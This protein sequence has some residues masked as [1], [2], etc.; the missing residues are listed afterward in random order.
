MLGLERLRAAFGALLT[1]CGLVA[2]VITFAVMCLVVTNAL[3]R[4]AFNAP[5]TGALELTEAALPLMIFL[6]LALTQAAGGHIK[7]VL[8][9]GRLPQGLARAAT[10]LAMLLGAGLFAWAAWAGWLMAMKSMAIGEMERGAIRFPIWPVKMAVFVGLGLLSVQFVLDAIWT[11]M[12][13]KLAD[14]DPELVE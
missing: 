14:A 2:G 4:F 3:M 9:T 5:I 10:V 7:V 1:G 12:G 11:A 6:S 8:L 13:G